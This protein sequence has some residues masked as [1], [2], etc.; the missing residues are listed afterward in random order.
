M[1]NA[2]RQLTILFYVFPF[3][4]SSCLGENDRK[5][6]SGLGFRGE[7]H[8][9]STH[10]SLCMIISQVLD[11]QAWNVRQ[12][13]RGLL[14]SSDNLAHHS[15]SLYGARVRW[16]RPGNDYFRLWIYKTKLSNIVSI[17]RTRSPVL[18]FQAKT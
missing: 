5:M 13:Q 3:Y 17:C 8:L 16:Q 9:L 11:L 7:T 10:H 12:W 15:F 1:V 4:P 6:S 18:D 2:R 14:I